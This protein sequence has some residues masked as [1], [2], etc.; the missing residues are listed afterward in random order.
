M[1]K[2]V[3]TEFVTLDGVAQAPG[4]PE[5][6]R[7]GGFT[8]GGWQAPLV[9]HETGEAMFA[10]ARGMDALLLGRRTYDIFAGYWPTAPAEIP[11]T[12]LLNRVPKYVASRTLQE[13]LG[14]EGSTLL[15]GDL[16]ENVAELT[17]RHDALHVIGSLDLVQSLLRL[18]VVDRLHL[19]LYPL[20]LGAGKRL[21]ADG[22]MPAAFRLTE[23]VGH[24]NGTLQLTYEAAGRPTY[25]NLAT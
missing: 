9:D 25:G 20:T 8:H 2:L 24:P 16:A 11:F 1:G 5:E 17:D 13:P 3:V 10:Q 23:S 18:R 4:Q 21:F 19:W 15:G 22:T 6:D 7:A 14:W 12:G